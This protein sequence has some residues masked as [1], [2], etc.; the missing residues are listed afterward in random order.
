MTDF[1]E[2]PPPPQRPE[3]EGHRR[4][5][6]LGPPDNELG[7]AVPTRLELVRTENLALAVLD[8]VAFSNGCIFDVAIRRRHPQKGGSPFHPFHDH[9]GWQPD[10]LH[11]GLQFADG[12]KATLDRAMWEHGPD[13]TPKG[14]MLMPHGGGGGA[15][16]WN[17]NMWLWP[18]PPPGPLAFVCEW[19]SESVA[20]MRE[21][22]DAGSILDAASHVK[23]LWADD[24]EAGGAK[25][26]VNFGK[27]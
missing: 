4:P 2:P 21:E 17:M 23:Q 18:L 16:S 25:V 26:I 8:L 1:F 9:G 24:G 15:R 27:D 5:A 12:A 10:A 20:L 22:I 14:P 13:A 3:P 19:Q 7:V 11:F 6:W